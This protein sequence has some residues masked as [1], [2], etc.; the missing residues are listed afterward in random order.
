MTIA[1]ENFLA[2]RNCRTYTVPVCEP[3]QGISSAIIPTSATFQ[4]RQRDTLDFCVDLRSFLTGI[5]DDIAL[6]NAAFA[7]ASSVTSAGVATG[8]PTIGGSGFTPEGTVSFVLTPSATAAVGDIYSI[9]MT[10]TTSTT[11]IGSGT[12]LPARVIVRR[13]AIVVVAG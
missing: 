2:P 13:I 8:A 3:P 12:V 1:F 5:G 7:I 6:A 10:A 4:I 11:T 9:D